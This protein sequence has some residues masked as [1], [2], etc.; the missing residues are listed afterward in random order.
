M[1]RNRHPLPVYSAL[2]DLEIQ[3]F[4]INLEPLLTRWKLISKYALH[5]HYLLMTVK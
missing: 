5:S 1:A 3:N 2:V 4:T